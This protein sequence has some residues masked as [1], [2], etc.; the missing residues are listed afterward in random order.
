MHDFQHFFFFQSFDD[1]A[2]II[3]CSSLIKIKIVIMSALT[4]C[5][6]WILDIQLI[7]NNSLINLRGTPLF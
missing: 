6:K 7:V 5:L 1:F 4:A 3:K 2:I